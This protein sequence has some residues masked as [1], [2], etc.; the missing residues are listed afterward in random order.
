M[1]KIYVIAEIGVNHNSDINKAKKL[2]KIAKKIG[3]D[4]VKFQAFKA[5][6]LTT[7]NCKLANYQK[8]TKFNNQYQMLKKYELKEDQIFK[9]NNFAKK[10]KIDF[11]LSVFDEISYF[12]DKK[13]NTKFIKIPSGEIT[14][15]PLLNLCSK[16][17]KRI[18]LSTGAS[19]LKEVQVAL[20]ILK[21]KDTII[22]H[23]NSAYPTPITDTNINI[24]KTLKNKFKKEVGLSDHTQST[25]IPAIA[26]GAGSNFIEKHITL[27]NKMIGPDHSSS[28]NPKDFKKM[29]ENIRI[30]E[31]SMGSSKKKISN[32]EKKNLKIIRKYIVAKKFIK[33]G[34]KLSKNNL[35]VKRSDGGTSAIY[36]NKYIG[37]KAKKNFIIDEKI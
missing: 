15:F 3:A 19:D 37:K 27:N 25:I 22:L 36:W 1:N 33:K 9:L 18:I 6:E 26:I 35:T 4:C 16:S 29:I 23:C 2:I 11:L 31:K 21:K 30:A 14:N 34:E 10:I 12:V 32:S 17:K 8:K 28:L 24:I 5:S 7:K 20:K 13:I